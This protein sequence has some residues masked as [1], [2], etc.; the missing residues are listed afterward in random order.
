MHTKQK[1]IVVHIF[2]PHTGQQWPV[3]QQIC[4]VHWS[5]AFSVFQLPLPQKSQLQDDKS[6]G[7]VAM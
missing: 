2:Y 1:P 6:E 3:F 5:E 7:V 4:S